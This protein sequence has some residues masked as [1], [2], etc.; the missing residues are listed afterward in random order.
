MPIDDR[1]ADRFVSEIQPEAE[2]AP[3][4]LGVLHGI[5]LATLLGW[6]REPATAPSPEIRE[7]LR[8]SYVRASLRE[9]SARQRDQSRR[10]SA[11]RRAIGGV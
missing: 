9:I 3:G 1:F 8:N 4:P 10:V 6:A 7:A 2:R 11:R 5:P